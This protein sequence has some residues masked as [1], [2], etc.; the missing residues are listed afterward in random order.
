MPALDNPKHE[1][2]E[3]QAVLRLC[4]ET[5]RFIWL[6]NV[7]RAKRGQIAGTV[8]N[9]GYR[10]IRFGGRCYLEHHLVW[11]FLYGVWPSQLDHKNCD[12]QD[13][14]PSNLRLA[15]NSEN[16]ANSKLFSTNSSGFKGVSRT[17]KGKWRAYI[18]KDHKQ[19]WLGVYDRPE[20]A[21][22]AYKLASHRYHGEFA[23]AG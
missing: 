13:N 15:D 4:P 21:H 5:F 1:L 9:N 23:R 8:Q 10:I 7:G 22:E 12:K 11:F 16:S 14:C 3:L 18:T 20:D 6:K 19:I 2:S 17:P